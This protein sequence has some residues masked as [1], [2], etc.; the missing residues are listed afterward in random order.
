M[1]VSFRC[2]SEVEHK[3]TAPVL[4]EHPGD[5]IEF[6]DISGISR[7][8]VHNSITNLSSCPI[9]ELPLSLLLLLP[10][11][12]HFLQ[13]GAK[14]VTEIITTTLFYITASH[15]W[16]NLGSSSQDCPVFAQTERFC[17]S[18]VATIRTVLEGNIYLLYLSMFYTEVLLV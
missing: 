15:S 5:A 12:R 10:F 1:I 13:E 17:V 14:D 8:C 16:Q 7:S 9:N 11:Y 18:C 3:F 6:R 2:W 4:L